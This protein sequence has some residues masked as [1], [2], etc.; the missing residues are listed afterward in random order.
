MSFCPFS[1]FYILRRAIL[2]LCKNK[3]ED[4]RK[5]KK[6]AKTYFSFHC[7]TFLVNSSLPISTLFIPSEASILSTTNW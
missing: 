1:F 3:N 7:Q 6:D 4:G 5:V 2:W